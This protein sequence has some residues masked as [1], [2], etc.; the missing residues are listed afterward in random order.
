MKIFLSTCLF[1]AILSEAEAEVCFVKK[2]GKK[3]ERKTCKTSKGGSCFVQ[4]NTTTLNGS[5]MFEDARGCTTDCTPENYSFTNENGR[6][7]RSYRSCCSGLDCADLFTQKMK[8][9]FNGK[10]CP[11]CCRS[12]SKACNGSKTIKCLNDE[13]QCIEF[14]VAH[15]D[16]AI[17]E[18]YFYGCAAP[19]FCELAKNSMHID[20]VSGTITRARCSD[21]L[22]SPKQLNYEG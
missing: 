16:S 6:Y 7:W 9:Q 15:D 8:Y 19:K 13:T 22:P 10:E 18:D 11:T 2:P 14:V 1:L 17:P 20:A 21:T 4:Y 12:L 3:F 5:F